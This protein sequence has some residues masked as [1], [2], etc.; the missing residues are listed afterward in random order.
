MSSGFWALVFDYPKP[1]LV[2]AALNH[3]RVFLAS[4]YSMLLYIASVVL[5]VKVCNLRWIGWR[6]VMPQG[7]QRTVMRN[8][9]AVALLLLWYRSSVQSWVA[10][11]CSSAT[12]DPTVL[13]CAIII[14]PLSALLSSALGRVVWHVSLA[15]TFFLILLQVFCYTSPPEMLLVSPVL[16]AQRL[17]SGT[18]AH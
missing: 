10:S 15:V 6:P 12:A 11:I 4:V 8:L 2:G 3:H 13:S 7:R 9:A 17:H 14:N 5:L 16:S 1:E 18:C